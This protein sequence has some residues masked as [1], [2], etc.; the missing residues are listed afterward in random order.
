M[1]RWSTRRAQ[2]EPIA[3]L[4][5]VLAVGVGLTAY[6]GVLGTALDPLDRNVAEPTLGRVHHEV[7]AD[8][9]VRPALL[10]EGVSAGPDGYRV[11]ATVTVD[12]RRWTAG[13][14]VP[15]NADRAD[16]PAGVALEPGVV[17]P[18]RLRVAVWS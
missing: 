10:D 2:T 8:G 6:A 7:T 14:I 17:R 18:G 3:A 4:V 1:S 9:V 5:A 11:N 15:L 16:R 12:E 13:P